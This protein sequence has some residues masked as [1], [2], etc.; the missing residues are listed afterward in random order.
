MKIVS[1]TFSKEECLLYLANLD[2]QC[3]YASIT[4]ETHTMC[5]KI[6]YDKSFHPRIFVEGDLVLVYD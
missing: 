5:V 2:K 4:N 3:F 6:K 1:D